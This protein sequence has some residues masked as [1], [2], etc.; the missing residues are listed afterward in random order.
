[1]SNEHQEQGVKAHNSQLLGR[2]I[3][4]EIDILDPEKSQFVAFQGIYN[5]GC[6]KASDM[7]A[8]NYVSIA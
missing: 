6:I 8:I 5:I 7:I 1:V 4:A 3:N 2:L